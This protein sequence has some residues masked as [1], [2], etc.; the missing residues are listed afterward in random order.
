MPG[1]G[2]HLHVHSKDTIE[3][4]CI[5]DSAFSPRFFFLCFLYISREPNIHME[6]VSVLPL[7]VNGLDLLSCIYCSVLFRNAQASAPNNVRDPSSRTSLSL[8]LGFFLPSH[9]TKTMLGGQGPHGSTE[10]D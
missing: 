6:S 10:V 9:R 2:S 3:M 8:A 4:I 7:G 1:C 5:A